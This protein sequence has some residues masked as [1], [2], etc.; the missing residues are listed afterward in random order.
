MNLRDAIDQDIFRIDDDQYSD[1]DFLAMT[2]DELE[3]IKLRISKKISGLSVAVAR[4]KGERASSDRYLICRSALSINERVHIYVKNLMKQ[5]Q[6]MRKTLGDCFMGK[7]EG[8]LSREVFESILSMAY[9]EMEAAQ[10]T[11]V[12][13]SVI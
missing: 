8:V 9:Q 11:T 12:K 7:A 13:E 1:A 10:R 4:R 5:R 6:R 2:L 3:T